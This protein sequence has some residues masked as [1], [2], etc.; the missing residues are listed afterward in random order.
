MTPQ[1]CIFAYERSMEWVR[2]FYPWALQLMGG[3]RNME[4]EPDD[5]VDLIEYVD[6]ECTVLVAINSPHI[7]QGPVI[8]EL[9]RREPDWSLSGC[10][11]FSY[12]LDDAAAS[13]TAFLACT[14]S[15]QANGA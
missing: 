7:D 1:N 13:L 12:S 8:K 14:N 5:R 2:Q 4:Y 3:P 9:E 11:F 10:G 15:R 6:H